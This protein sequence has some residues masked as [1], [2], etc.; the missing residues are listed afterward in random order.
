MTQNRKSNRKKW[1][2]IGGGVVVVAILAIGYLG[3]T[4][5]RARLVEEVNTGDIVTAFV[6]DLSA[7]ASAA[8]QVL[9]Q[10]QADLTLG[11]SGRVEQVLVRI[12]DE[13][14]AGDVLVQLESDA[15][16]RSVASAEQNVIIQEANL[17]ELRKGASASDIAAAEAQV[18]SAQAQLDDLRNGPSA[19]EIAAAQAN[20]DVARAGV[21]SAS[22]QVNQATAGASDAE[23]AA[24]EQ[25]VAVAEQNYL[26][27]KQAH[28]RTLEC[29]TLPNGEETCPL[30]GAPEEQARASLRAAEANLAQARA[31]LEALQNP[32][33]NTVS[34]AQAGV[35]SASAQVAAAQA[36]LDQLLQGA[37]SAQIAAAE[38]QL[39]Q[40][41]ASLASLREGSS[42]E[43]LAT[44]E[45][46]LAQARINLEEAQANLAKA[47]LTAPFSGVVTAVYI[48]EGEQ[49][50]GVV[51]QLVDTESLEVVLDVDEIDVGSLALGQPARVTLE[52]W[53]DDV[54]ESEITSIA[55]SGKTSASSALVS[56]E[57][58]LSLGRTDLPVRVGMTANADLITGERKGVLLLPN[59]AINADRSAGTYSVNLVQTDANGVQS[60][61]SVP[62]TI[63]LRD[64]DYTQITSG[65]AEG[66][67]VLIGNELPVVRFGPP[68]GNGGGPFG[69][70][71]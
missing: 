15:L 17:S 47:T 39:I 48:A 53:P 3:I 51:L 57:V 30:L 1:L 50:G 12:G 16:A 54:I 37:T 61:E 38:A 11:I 56:Y 4:N 34:G 65:L 40:T 6:G 49:A 33:E 21:W 27:A 52:S 59:A 68:D 9:P 5:A 67:Q 36:Q 14:Q 26:Q 22:A 55:P 44:A 23:I 2:W 32:N 46:Q 66:D 70:N 63:G 10:R 45:A 58:H 43:R 28:D 41:Q 64:G 31:Q 24:A 35:S 25:Q 20:V 18:A 69:R 62:V 7:T 19:E 71:N 8:G 60:F 13:V 42:P 29:F